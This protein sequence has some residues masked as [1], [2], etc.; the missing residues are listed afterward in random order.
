MIKKLIYTLLFASPVLFSACTEE[1][2]IDLG[3]VDPELVV[4]GCLTTDTIAHTIY[5]KTTANYFANK[6][7]DVV[8]GATVVITDGQTIIPLTED[9]AQKGTY[10]TAS[11]VYGLPGH[12]YVLNISNVDIN[13]DGVKETYQA[14]CMLNAVP[15]IDSISIEKAKRFYKDVWEVKVSAQDPP[16]VRNSY[17]FR[18]YRNN[19][20]ISDTITEWGITDDEMYNGNYMDN[21]TVMDFNSD[22]PDEILVDGDLITLEMCGITKDYLD[23]INEVDEAYNGSNLLFGGQPANIRTN[24]K[25]TYPARSDGKGVRGYFAAY[26]ISRYSRTYHV[27]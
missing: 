9:A 14:S 4:D 27:K 7:A 26:S 1:I 21:V 8:S 19:V 10:R 23:F 15:K 13:N 5:L 2:S 11:N 20:C 18:T 17:L 16:V 22:K 3:T 24:L 6:P 12:N 25:Q